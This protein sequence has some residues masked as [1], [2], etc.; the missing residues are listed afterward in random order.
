[1]NI[2]DAD[3][4]AGR[5]EPFLP[6]INGTK[7]NA[8]QQPRTV[9]KMKKTDGSGQ[10]LRTLSKND[11]GQ[12]R[13]SPQ[14]KVC[15]ELLRMGYHRSFSELYSLLIGCE[16]RCLEQQQ[17]SLDAL[18]VHLSRAEDAQRTGDWAG[19]C[20]SHL[21]LAGRPWA[22]EE[23]WISL[24]FY[25]RSL[26]A[27]LRLPSAHHETL[28]TSRLAALHLQLGDL[29]EARRYSERFLQ[30]AEAE[31]EQTDPMEGGPE[32]EQADPMDGGPEREQADMEGG[33]SVREQASRL[34]VQV[35]IRLAE[36]PV[37]QPRAIKLLHEAYHTATHCD[38]SSVKGEAAYKLGL[39]YQRTGDHSSALEF[40]TVSM[41]N[42]RLLQDTDALGKTYKAL[43]Q[44]EQ[45]TTV[46]V[47][48]LEKYVDVSHINGHQ[49][50]LQD[51]YM[52]LGASYECQGQYSRCI[53]YYQQGYDLACSLGDV[54]RIQRAQVLVGCAR[55][56]SL[57]WSYGTDW[58]L[59]TPTSQR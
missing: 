41:E 55:A 18:Q 2:S 37:H 42:F 25:Q 30:L 46:K 12:F 19:V 40:L 16:E 59:A 53:E 31:R 43:S 13:N 39:A 20:A 1:M 35:Y 50:N 26:E 56:H 17:D 34:L 4:E 58:K 11:I 51:A 57:P 52:S 9:K 5:T 28:V 36:L 33:G 14:H 24:H 44:S 32:R 7:R 10:T 48:Y 49:G 8:A 3:E 47:E 45:I 22:P 15:V 54:E 21:S 23:Q 27:A 6:D 38:D 29:E